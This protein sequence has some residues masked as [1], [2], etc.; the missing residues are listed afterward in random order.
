[1]TN[2]NPETHQTIRVGGIKL[3]PEL[4]QFSFSRTP[5]QDSLL[6]TILERIAAHGINISFLSLSSTDNGSHISLCV[7]SEHLIFVKNLIENLLPEDQALVCVSSV[8]TLTLFPHRNDLGLLGAVISLFAKAKLPIY[9]IGTSISA[10]AINTEYRLLQE[11]IEHL[12]SIIE[13][14]QN[15]S[16]FRHEFDV[17]QI[18]P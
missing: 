2:T 12:T 18:T 8:G 10:L 11:A 1:M 3:S 16:P 17:Q 7:L 4:V 9:G 5:D 13:L 14:P 6:S 15:H